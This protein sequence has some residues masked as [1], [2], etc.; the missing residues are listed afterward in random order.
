MVGHDFAT[1]LELYGPDRLDQRRMTI[2]ESFAYCRRLA[3]TH[4]ENF[5]VAS[6][7]VPK[8]LR[9]HLC[10]LYAY[11][12]WSDDLADETGNPEQSVELLA[13]WQQQ[14]S[15]C[16]LGQARHPVFIALA[17]TVERFDL[18]QEPF[19]DLLF[20]FRQDQAINRYATIDDLLGYC[21]NSANPVGRLV[22]Y[23]GRCHTEQNVEFSN[24][25][26][27]GLQLVN[28]CQDV[29]RDYDR[30]RI[31]LPQESCRRFKYDE[32]MFARRQFDSA[33]Q[34]LM[35]HEVDRAESFLTAG[36]PLVD[37]VESDLK[38]PVDLFIRGGIATVAAI[39]G[40]GYNVW[41]QRPTV[42][43]WKKALLLATAWWRRHGGSK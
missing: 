40:I 24:G 19:D 1:Q 32:S 7:F 31:Y 3:A 15:D 22:L 36:W 33:F 2:D 34:E 35:K 23:L 10:N 26:C 41:E 43:K 38:V 27:T 16:F 39:R 42:G 20:A 25:I 12:R 11:C 18:P 6:W 28:F 4:Y 8:H 14:L 13:W 21:R 29:A 9:Q 5:T 37:C 30:G 17:Q